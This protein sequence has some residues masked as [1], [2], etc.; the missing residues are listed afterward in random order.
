[1]K[2]IVCHCKCSSYDV[3]IGRGPDPLTGIEGKWG[4]PFQIGKDGT[5]REVIEKY[6]EW[7]VKQPELMAAL[8]E[9]KGKRLAC[10]CRPAA[11]HGDVL[12]ALA[13]KTGRAEEKEEPG[14]LFD[15][16]GSRN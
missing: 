8:P 5:R 12:A 11:C 13:D 4:N 10:W 7:I 15:G 16:D 14:G 3:Y 9:L 1:M 2:T 6:R